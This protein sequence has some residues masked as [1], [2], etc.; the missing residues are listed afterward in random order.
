MKASLRLI[1]LTDRHQAWRDGWGFCHSWS[2]G[3]VWSFTDG[4][5][6]FWSRSWDGVFPQSFVP[7][8]PQPFRSDEVV[9]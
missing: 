7:E 6:D 9:W 1:T 2:R 5:I 8:K 4:Q 3:F